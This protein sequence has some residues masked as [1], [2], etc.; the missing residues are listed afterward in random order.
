MKVIYSSHFLKEYR[1]LSVEIKN[2]AE[3][4]EKI[5]KNNPFDSRLK[6]H[7]L[8]GNLKDFWSFSIDFKN[9]IIFEFIDK[10]LFGFILLGHMMFINEVKYKNFIEIF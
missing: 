8:T 1:K 6:T 7:K 3:K 9:R 2:I 10:I 4:K 5:L